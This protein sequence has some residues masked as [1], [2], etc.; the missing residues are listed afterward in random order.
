MRRRKYIVGIRRPVAAALTK[1]DKK[2]L[3]EWVLD[4][5]SPLDNP[6]YICHEDSRP[7]DYIAAL[8]FVYE[9]QNEM[10]A[11]TEEIAACIPD[12]QTLGELPF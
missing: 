8:L 1:S 3:A 4:G 10:E 2:A 6:W 7:F 11:C 9:M 12:N 5:N